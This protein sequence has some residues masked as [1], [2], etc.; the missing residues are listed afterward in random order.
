[1][2]TKTLEL[3]IAETDTVDFNPLNIRQENSEYLVGVRGCKSYLCISEA[4][5]QAIRLLRGGLAVGV[6]N[7]RLADALGTARVTLVPLLEKLLAAGAIQSIGGQKLQRLGRLQDG[8][9]M[10]MRP[11]RISWLFSK[12][13]A[14]AYAIL[15]GIALALLV[16]APWPLLRP[17]QLAGMPYSVLAT[18][19]IVVALAN[20]VKHEMAHALAA[21]SSGISTRFSIGHRFLFPVLQ[22]DLTDLWVV[23]RKRR[24]IVYAAGMISDLLTLAVLV[25]AACCTAWLQSRK[26][27][28]LPASQLITFFSVAFFVIASNILWQGNIFVRTDLYYILANALNCRNL[29]G[30]AAAYLRSIAGKLFIRHRGSGGATSAPPPFVIKAYAFVVVAGYTIVAI[31]FVANMLTSLHA[32]RSHSFGTLPAASFLRLNGGDRAVMIAIMIFILTWLAYS[33]GKELRR[34]SIVYRILCAGEI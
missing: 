29:H 7:Q 23:D 30:D 9:L 11:D 12:P 31:L 24:Y 34:E 26:I 28:W 6:V 15:M 14:A 3:R 2:R 8:P 19:C 5:M 10:S 21:W 27:S 25:I 17:S 13:A 18:L 22:T 33:K 4:G 16:F 20:A 32:L 1:M